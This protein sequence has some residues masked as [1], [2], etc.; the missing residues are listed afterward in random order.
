M[1]ITI[2]IDIDFFALL[3]AKLKRMT[4]KYYPADHLIHLLLIWFYR[5]YSETNVKKHLPF[6]IDKQKE[7]EKAIEQ[8]ERIKLK[9][10]FNK[11]F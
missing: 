2:P 5:Y 7:K 11:I 9:N 6:V 1:Y 8:R 3:Q 4:G 10:K